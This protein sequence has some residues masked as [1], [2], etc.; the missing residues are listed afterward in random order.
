LSWH[1]SNSTQ[2]T[3]Y[4]TYLLLQLVNTT[5]EDVSFKEHL[6]YDV[7]LGVIE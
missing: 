1:E 4:D 3:A 2:T 6:P 5:V 7:V